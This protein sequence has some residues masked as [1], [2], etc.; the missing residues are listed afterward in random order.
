MALYVIVMVWSASLLNRMGD[1]LWRVPIA[2]ST[3]I[4]IYPWYRFSLPLSSFGLLEQPTSPAG[5]AEILE[6]E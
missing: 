4:P 6:Q 5:T 2:L 1:S 3:V